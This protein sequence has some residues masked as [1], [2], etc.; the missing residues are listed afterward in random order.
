DVKWTDLDEAIPAFFAGA[1]MALAYSITSGI[2]A[3]FIFYCIVKL[4]RKKSK[5][6]HPIL[7]V[8]TLLFILN[9]VLQAVV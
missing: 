2:A 3:A 1:F 7:V 9:F 6:L 8:S 4:C 5:D